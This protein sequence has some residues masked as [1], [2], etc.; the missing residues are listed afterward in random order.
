MNER[1][2]EKLTQER[3]ARI[4]SAA[5]Y[6]VITAICRDGRVCAA[7]LRLLL[8]THPQTQT[9]TYTRI[10]QSK[11]GQSAPYPAYNSTHV[12]SNV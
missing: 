10:L 11:G 6:E 7:Y 4:K 8:R 5:L 12:L 9:H 2:G 3:D 1:T